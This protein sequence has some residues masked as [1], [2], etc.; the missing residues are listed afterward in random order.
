MKDA[1]PFTEEQLSA[2]RAQYE[3]DKTRRIA[4]N[5]L[6]KTGLADAAFCGTEAARMHHNFSIEIP[7][8]PVTN[9][10]ASGRCWMFAALNVLR[11]R[12]ASKMGLEDFE[13]SQSYLAFWDKFERANYFLETI[14][15]TLDLDADDRV[16]ATVLQNGVHDG[17]QWDMFCALVDKYGC[18]PKS[19]MPETF[20]SSNSNMMNKYITLKLREYAM[21]LRDAAKA[22][23]GMDELEQMKEQMMGEVYGMLCI[24]L[25]QPPQTFTWEYRDK[26][27]N[28]HR[29]ENL[30]PKAFFDKF[31]GQKLDEFISIINAPTA[32]KPYNRTYT[33]AYLGNVCEGRQIK[34][35]NLTSEEQKQLAIKQLEDGHPVWFGCDVGQFLTRD[36]GIMG[37][38]NF[39]MEQLLGVKFGMDKAQRLDYHESVL[40]HAMV[41]L[42]VNLVNGKPNRWKVENSWSDKS[43]Q[44]GYYLMTDEWFDEFN[45]QVVINKKY[46]TDEQRKAFEQEPIVLKP[47]DPMGSLA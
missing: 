26:D 9:Q 34:Y 41:F 16:L 28:F 38:K 18:V 10:K 5:A 44:D 36:S 32:D 13:L 42:G 1:V 20:Q 40:T 4:A 6:S 30:T 14:L 22:G 25:G 35:L 7:T 15:D 19:V 31:V 24:C 11:E 17:G 3:N 39:G 46:L 12:V 27:K 29:E 45:Y 37:M 8:L 21:Q 47:W 23:K 2:F 43:G 33:V